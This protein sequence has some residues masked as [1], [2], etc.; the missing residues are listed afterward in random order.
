MPVAFMYI[1]FSAITDRYVFSWNLALKGILI[2]SR[3]KRKR[4]NIY[5]II[6][7]YVSTYADPL[8][9]HPCPPFLKDLILDLPANRKMEWKLT[10]ISLLSSPTSGFGIDL[11]LGPALGHRKA[12]E[13]TQG[14]IY[15]GV[16]R[17]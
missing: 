2:P 5:Q 17:S 12:H 16:R 10:T 1:T 7:V 14:L 11:G 3:L 4:N 8:S 9:I 6:W 13:L 15:G